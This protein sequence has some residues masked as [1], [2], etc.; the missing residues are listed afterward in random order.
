MIRSTLKNL[1]SS[2]TVACAVA[3]V[4]LG[5]IFSLGGCVVVAAGAAGAGTYAY[6]TGELSSVEQAK[7]DKCWSA[8]QSAVKDLQFTVKEQSKDALQARMVAQQADKTDI[9]ISLE[10]E[11]DTLTKIRIRVGVFGDENT[12]RIVMDKIKSKL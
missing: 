9:K 1:S 6:V 11:T 12:S 10:R 5:S 8:V 4:V 2:R 7:L 3:A